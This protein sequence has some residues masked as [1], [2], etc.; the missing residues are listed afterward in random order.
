V[1]RLSVGLECRQ[2]D[3]RTAILPTIGKFREEWKYK[4]KAVAKVIIRRAWL[5]GMMVRDDFP[6]P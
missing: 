4:A 5:L 3:T 1:S 2:N 6:G